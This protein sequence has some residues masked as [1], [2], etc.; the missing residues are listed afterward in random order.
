MAEGDASH[1]SG[2]PKELAHIEGHSISRTGEQI[3]ANMALHQWD[4][5]VRNWIV[6]LGVLSILFLALGGA[7]MVLQLL[8]HQPQENSMALPKGV[9]GAPLFGI[10]TTF[11]ITPT[12][13]THSDS[14]LITLTMTNIEKEPVR[15]R[16]LSCIEH[17][18]ELYDASGELVFWKSGAMLR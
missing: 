12:V 3:G 7:L 11:G 9:S 2:L 14:V 6:I 5:R 10:V 17:H 13:V 16:Y 15:F 1:T 4:Y 8:W 18:V